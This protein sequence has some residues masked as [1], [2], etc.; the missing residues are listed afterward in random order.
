MTKQFEKL[1]NSQWAGISPFLPL[2]RKRRSELRQVINAILWLLRTGC[3]WRNLPE[4]YLHWQTVY[5][6]FDRWKVDG[7]ARA[8]QPGVKPDGP[9]TAGAR[10]LPLGVL[11]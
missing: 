10:G 8:H 5:Y 1:T 6:Y 7:D 2:N 9:Q 11:Y 4:N 3:Q